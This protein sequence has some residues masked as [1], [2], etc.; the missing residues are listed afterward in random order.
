MA[1]F[2]RVRWPQSHHRGSAR[3]TLYVAVLT[4]SRKRLVDIREPASIKFTTFRQLANGDDPADPSLLRTRILSPKLSLR[5]RPSDPHCSTRQFNPIQIT[6]DLDAG[7]R[8]S[9]TL[10]VS[11]SGISVPQAIGPSRS[12]IRNPFA[13]SPPWSETN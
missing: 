11:R 3:L 12:L 2:Q 13:M 5:D 10:G 4:V 1:H 9:T 7:F 6:S 8:I